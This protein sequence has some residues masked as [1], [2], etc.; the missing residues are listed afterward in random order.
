MKLENLRWLILILL[1][2]HTLPVLLPTMASDIPTSRPQEGSG[3]AT[4]Q[5]D[6]I[7]PP[8]IS[9]LADIEKTAPLPSGSETT[10]DQFQVTFD[11]PT[12]STNPLNW[13]KRMKWTVTLVLAISEYNSSA[14]VAR[15]FALGCSRMYQFRNKSR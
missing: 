15:Y 3:H 14:P 12:D 4:E 8:P 6:S 10:V 11:S 1:G 5:L 7:Q 9:L 13:S 2:N